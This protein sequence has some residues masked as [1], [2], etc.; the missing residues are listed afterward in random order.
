MNE[1]NLSNII[2]EEIKNFDFLGNDEFLKEQETTDLLINE[3]LQKQFICDSLLN[4]NNKIKIAKIVDSSI[5]GN[6]DDSTA[7]NASHV[8]LDYI[9]DIEYLYDT[10][11]EPI[12]FNLTFQGENIGISVD[13]DVDMGDGYN[14]PPEGSSWYDEFQ[15]EDIDV[16]IFTLDGNDVRFIAFEKAPPRI[17]TLFIRQYTQNFIE[18]QTMEIKTPE[19]KDSVQNVGYC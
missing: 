12:K 13:D 7:E 18:S 1:I 10:T 3:E 14:Y 15:W 5:S 6:W 16:T 17:Q 4:T 8:S 2:T 11:K 19:V 9:V